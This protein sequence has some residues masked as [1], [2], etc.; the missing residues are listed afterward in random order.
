LI[1]L[2]GGLG[3]LAGV[4]AAGAAAGAAGLGGLAGVD[5]CCPHPCV[6]IAAHIIGTK[7]FF[8]YRKC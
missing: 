1:G 6:A 8:I 3:W 5:G 2:S 7:N 4:P